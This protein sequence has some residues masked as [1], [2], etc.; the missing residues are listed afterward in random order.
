MHPGEPD[1]DVPARMTEDR[2]PPG[3]GGG[4]G[5][6]DGP[7]QMSKPALPSLRPVSFA[8]RM[9]NVGW[10]EW[11]RLVLA[12]IG[13]GAVFKAGG[14]NPFAA[15]FTIGKGL[16]QILT[17]V[18][19]IIGWAAQVGAMPLLLGSLAAVPA[20]LVW[21]AIL[22]LL[23]RDHPPGKHPAGAHP[24][25]KHPRGRPRTPRGR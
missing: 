7:Q 10:K 17:G 3:A 4:S 12:C 8:G 5:E 21:R 18:L 23:N 6:A 20:W 9:F 1:R 22:T 16:G 11:V 15:D 14:F 25:A 13:I 2:P 24:P 19:G